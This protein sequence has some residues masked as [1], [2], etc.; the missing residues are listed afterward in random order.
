MLTPL[1]TMR[2]RAVVIIG[3]G[4]ILV[5]A[6]AQT[7]SQSIGSLLETAPSLAQ[8]DR[9]GEDSLVVNEQI[10]FLYYKNLE[11]ADR[12]F[13]KTLG[14]RKTTDQDWVKIF[15]TVSGSSIGAVQEG[16]GSLRTAVDKPLMISWVVDDV[17]SWHDRLVARGVKIVKPIHPSTDPPMKSFLFEDPTGYTFELIQWLKRR[18]SGSVRDW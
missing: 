6:V 16:R 14:L 11:V 7:R 17:E 12:F 2:F 3:A 5:A 8:P 10:V 13:E 1:R 15:Q 18:S 9:R 4:V